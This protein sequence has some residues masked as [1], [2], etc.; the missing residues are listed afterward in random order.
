[1]SAL[2]HDDF[3]EAHRPLYRHEAL[4]LLL[5]LEAPPAS[6]NQILFGLCAYELDDTGSLLF[7]HPRHSERGALDLPSN[8][9]LVAHAHFRDEDGE[10]IEV[11]L[12]ADQLGLPATLDMS[13]PDL[14]AV[15]TY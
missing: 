5:L 2:R 12:E 8:L 4:L 1:M 13:R 10:I 11:T 6:H 14:R 15:R 3:T 7:V 9:K